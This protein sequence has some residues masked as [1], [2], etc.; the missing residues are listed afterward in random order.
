[1][2]KKNIIVCSVIFAALVSLWIVLGIVIKNN[3]L[4]FF[5]LSVILGFVVNGIYL[6]SLCWMQVLSVLRS[7]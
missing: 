1:M 6:K 3:V 5:P 7:R 4:E 2:K